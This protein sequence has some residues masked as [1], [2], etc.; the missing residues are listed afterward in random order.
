MFIVHGQFFWLNILWAYHGTWVKSWDLACNFRSFTRFHPAIAPW[1]QVARALPSGRQ[2]AAR[3][4]GTALSTSLVL[5]FGL[6][7]LC[8]GN[9]EDVEGTMN[10]EVGWAKPWT[11]GDITM[12]YPSTGTKLHFF[13]ILLKLI[14]YFPDGKST[15][16]RISW[17]ANPKRWEMYGEMGLVMSSMCFSSPGD[18]YIYN[19]IY[20]Y[21]II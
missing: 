20:I 4:L 16:W 5:G 12:I 19:I 7:L 18:M 9:V 8:P 21:D 10:G 3:C 11:L 2:R 6:T 14:C 1:P 17:E 15:A 13:W